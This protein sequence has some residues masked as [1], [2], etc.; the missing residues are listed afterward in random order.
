MTSAAVQHV[1]LA[2]PRR[3]DEHHHSHSWILLSAG[4]LRFRPLRRARE[5]EID[6]PSEE[7]SGT[8]D[9]PATSR[10]VAPRVLADV[11]RDDPGLELEQLRVARVDRGAD[12][13][14]LAGAPGLEASEVRKHAATRQGDRLVDLEVVRIA[15]NEHD[16]AVEVHGLR[17]EHVDVVRERVPV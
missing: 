4:S 3:L 5:A 7:N 1:G 2:T 12:P 17:A 9:S 15:V 13:V 14:R 10:A 16:L 8:S 11:S 6:T